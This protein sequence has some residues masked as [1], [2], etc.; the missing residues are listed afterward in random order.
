[1]QILMTEEVTLQHDTVTPLQRPTLR[2]TKWRLGGYIF[3]E[4]T[5]RHTLITN[6]PHQINVSDQ[7][8][9]HAQLQAHLLWT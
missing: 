5:E 2:L 3:T 4:Q 9:E 7:A 6:N 1:M 8:I